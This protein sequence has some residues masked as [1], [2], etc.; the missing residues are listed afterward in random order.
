MGMNR[1]DHDHDDPETAARRAADQAD[2]PAAAT[3]SALLRMEGAVDAV[4]SPRDARLEQIDL[5]L[6]DLRALA[7]H[8]ENAEADLREAEAQPRWTPTP[9]E[10]LY[11]PGL[12][13][14][15]LADKS[16]VAL[17][18]TAD[19]HMHTEWSDGD[20]LDDVLESAVAAGL[21]VIAITDHD[22]IEGALEA[23][24]RAHARRLPLAVVPGIEVSTRDGHVGALFVTEP[25]PADESAAATIERIHAAG[26]LAVAHHP[27]APRLIETLLRVRLGCKELIQELPFDAI[28]CTN[29]VPGY[30]TKYNIAAVDALAKRRVRVGVTGSSDAHGARFVGKG[31]TYFAGNAGVRSLHT[32]LDQGLTLGAEGYWKTSEKLAYRWHLTKAI[33]RNLLR[34]NG[35]VN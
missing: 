32:S 6:E 35:S 14:A 1:L 23:R 34:R 7:P 4:R 3:P 33:V 11:L 2:A 30:G 13:L 27:F 26:G 25:I 19:L 5:Y 15:G 8:E 16:K 12:R 18:N 31:R 28:E 21:D 22:E 9:Y 10:E 24:R 29:A 17:Q 20:P